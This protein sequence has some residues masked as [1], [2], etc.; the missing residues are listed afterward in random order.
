MPIN[1]LYHTWIQRIREL[2][3]DQRITQI[4]RFYLADCKDIPKP[5]GQFEPGCGEDPW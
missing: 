5:F 1:T 4:S 2:R 3:P